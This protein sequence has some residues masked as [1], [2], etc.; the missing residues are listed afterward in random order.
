MNEAGVKHVIA[1]LDA[2][3]GGHEVLRRAAARALGELDAPGATELLAQVMRLA[4]ARHAPAMRV[5]PAFL[6]ALALD[7][8]VIPHLEQLRQVATLHEQH[9]VAVVFAEGEAVQRYER[10]AAAR[11]DARLFTAPLGVLK[12]RA[13]LTKNPDELSRLAVA[14]D[15]SVI[16]EVLKNSRLTEDLVVR[17]A[18]RRPALPEPLTEIWASVRWNNRPAVRRALVFNPYLPPEV[19]VKIVPTLAPADLKAVAADGQLHLSVRELAARLA[20]SPGNRS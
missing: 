13:R 19:G 17:I 16:R 5:L 11:A 6:Q 7:G 1:R 10:D 3:G 18:S 15:A 2:L 20:A 4:V 14:S 9:E 12:S 8:D